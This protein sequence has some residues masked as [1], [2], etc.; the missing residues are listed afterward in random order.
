MIKCP[1]AKFQAG[2]GHPSG[3]S[4]VRKAVVNWGLGISWTLRHW[5]LV[6]RPLAI[7]LFLCA[8]L[9][10]TGC[11]TT[12]QYN[13]VRTGDPLID[14]RT[15]IAQGP[16]KDRVLWQ[17]RTGLAAMRRGNYDEAARMFDAA[18]DRIEGI[19]GPN[20]SARKAR[21][22]F[23]EEARKTFIGEPYERVMAY[24]YRGIL[25]WMEGDLGNARA[26]FRSAQLMDS[27]AESREYASDYVLLD[28]LEGLATLKL[29][30]GG[31]DAYERAQELFDKGILPEYSRAMNTLVFM[32][33]GTGPTKYATGEYKEELRFREGRSAVRGAWLNLGNKKIRMLPMDD[34]NFQATTRGGRVMDHILDN[35]AVFKAS[36]DT[37]G[38]AA[39]LSGVVVGSQRGTQEIGLGLIAAG[40]ISK[41]FSAATTPRADTR[42][43]DNLPQYLSFVGL[44]LPPGP[45]TATVEFTD[46]AGNVLPSMTKIVQFT[47]SPESDTVLFVS[48]RNV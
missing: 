11:A 29:S 39:L 45:H 2:G 33:F 25:F 28:Y 48:D 32:E 18:L 38:N 34:L 46:G 10:L 5:S 36:T 42:A 1:I 4:H 30:G 14:G 35:K 44:E 20:K 9:L 23:S 41:A 22:Y 6:I 27:D 8:A 40:L 21:S 31:A 7:L 12:R 15:A 43:W 16:E 24:F 26:C 47:V 17:Y 37:F 3:C 13:W 19:Y